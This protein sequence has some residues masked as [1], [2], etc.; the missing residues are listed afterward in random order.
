MVH[1]AHPCHGQPPG[2]V[3]LQWTASLKAGAAYY[4]ELPIPAAL[5]VS[6]KL[7]GYGTLTAILDPH[8]LVSEIAGSNYFSARLETAVQIERDGKTHNL[9]GSLDTKKITEQE[10]RELD[11]KWSPL[12]HHHKKFKG[13][14]CHGDN[15]RIY[16]RI[17]TRDLYLYGYNH[18]DETPEMTVNFVLT[19]GTGWESDAVFNQ[20]H[21]SLGA[22]VENSTIETLV[23]VET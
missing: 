22:F 14:S 15:L 3:T 2:A 12:R 8:P 1:P 10:A 9:L 11:H 21:A 16:A 19:I 17:F 6:G 4:W 5:R 23:E 18:P 13:I 20:M 7:R